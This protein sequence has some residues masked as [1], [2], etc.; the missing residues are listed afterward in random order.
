MGTDWNFGRDPK[1]LE[2]I[3][4]LSGDTSGGEGYN[5]D[6]NADTNAN[7]SSYFKKALPDK[8]NRALEDIGK[9]IA[10][11]MGKQ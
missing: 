5:A 7:H 4:H 3:G 1:E 9:V 2:G 6:P 11:S 8:R 10:D